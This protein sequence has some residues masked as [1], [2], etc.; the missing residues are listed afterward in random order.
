MNAPAQKA[1]VIQTSARVQRRRH[2]WHKF[3]AAL[4]FNHLNTSRLVTLAAD[5]Q[6][7]RTEHSGSSDRQ[8]INVPYASQLFESLTGAKVGDGISYT[9]P[10]SATRR[11]A[12][13]DVDQGVQWAVQLINHP[14]SMSQLVQ[15]VFTP[16]LNINIKHAADF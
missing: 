14:P 4:A 5:Q 6:P 13:L 1:A 2:L 16:M 10:S 9:C 12:H 8:H 7:H 15:L 3:H 11:K